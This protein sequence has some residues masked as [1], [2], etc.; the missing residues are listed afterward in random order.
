MDKNIGAAL[1]TPANKNYYYGLYGIERIGVASGRKY[2]DTLDWYATGADTLVNTQG[3]NGNWAA[4]GAG[5]QRGL[6]HS[7]FG[8]RPRTGCDEQA[9]ILA[10][11]ARQS[12]ARTMEQ[13][14]RDCANLVRSIGRSLERD[15]NWQIVNL[16]VGSADL[17]DAPILYICGN[18]ELSFSNEELA[19]LRSFAEEGGLILGNAD[20]GSLAFS[21]SFLKL[22]H[23][24]FPRYEFRDLPVNH[25]I[26]T[27]EQSKW[28]TGGK[29]SSPGP[30]KWRARAHAACSRSGPVA[31]V[32]RTP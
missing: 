2:F 21:S 17:H 10:F 7:L 19:K 22:G 24:L 16:K 6:Q 30:V 27:D 29:A 11:R 20:C 5:S 12:C 3:R 32:S 8:S 28:I 18:K 9:R 4:I 14:P 1:T 15:L 23:L 31:C 26:Y 25:V 13:R